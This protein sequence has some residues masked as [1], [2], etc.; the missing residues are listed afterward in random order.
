MIAEDSGTV[1]QA[2]PAQQPAEA[3]RATATEALHMAG[4]AIV[5]GGIAVVLTAVAIPISLGMGVA[6]GVRSIAKKL[7]GT[8]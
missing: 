5:T 7:R 3:G 6:W 1:T 2:R 4:S 8:E